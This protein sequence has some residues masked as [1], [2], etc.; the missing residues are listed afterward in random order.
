MALK[1]EVFTAGTSLC[2]PVV[3]LVKEMACQKCEVVESRKR[4]PAGC[5]SGGLLLRAVRCGGRG[6]S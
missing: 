4:K 6:S 2:A 3:T 5:R 1:I